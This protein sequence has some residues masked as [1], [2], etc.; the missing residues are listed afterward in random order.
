MKYSHQVSDLMKDKSR[1]MSVPLMLSEASVGM[2]GDRTNG[3]WVGFAME[4]NEGF[5]DR[6]RFQAWGC[7]HLLAACAFVS[8]YFEGR[9]VCDIDTLD[10]ADLMRSLQIPTE[11]AGKILI[12]QDALVACRNRSS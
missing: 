11:K 8:E 3:C 12:L 4:C 1:L 10:T 6:V 7:P 9:P 5:I 2:A